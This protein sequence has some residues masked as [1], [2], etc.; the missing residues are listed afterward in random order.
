MELSSLYLT[1]CSYGE[2]KGQVSGEIIFAGDAGKVTLALGP[3]E[4]Q[5]ILRICA[6]RLVAQSQEIAVNLT[7]EVI[8][9]SSTPLLSKE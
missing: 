9:S 3:K 6:V 5:E 2:H 4:A 1:R 7:A 8:E